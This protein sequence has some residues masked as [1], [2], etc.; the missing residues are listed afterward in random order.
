MRWLWGL[1]DGALTSR[2]RS[3]AAC[4]SPSTAT[5]G[6][7]A[8]AARSAERAT[9]T[10]TSSCT[11]TCAV[12]K[13][14]GIV[15]GPTARFG[16]A[17]RITRRASAATAD[18][19]GHRTALRCRADPRRPSVAGRWPCKGRR[20]VAQR[21][22]VGVGRE[23]VIGGQRRN[24]GGRRPPVAGVASPP[25]WWKWSWFMTRISGTSPSDDR[26]RRPN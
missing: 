24:G 8:G 6:T 20:A 14:K 1:H 5:A 22:C 12:R 23:R 18:R 16:R 7:W 25:G 19:W 26:T 11:A 4:W 21:P 10:P 3:P 2:K 9:A 17:K 13:R 15:C